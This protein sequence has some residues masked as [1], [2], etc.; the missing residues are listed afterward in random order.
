[1]DL[2]EATD[3]APS[4]RHPWE[5]ARL[6]VLHRLIDRHVP[7]ADGSI[8]VDIGCGDAFVIGELAKAFPSARFYGVDAAFTSASAQQRQRSLP[9]NVHLFSQLD[10]VPADRAAALV[11][12]MDVIE[13]I[14]DDHAFLVD[15][16]RRPIAGATTRAIVTVPAYQSLF[17]SHDIFLKHFRRYTNRQLRDRLEGAGLRIDDI[18]YFFSSLLPLRILSVI[19]E[20]ISPP[21]TASGT[22]LSEYRGGG[23]STALLSGILKAD[24]FSTLM[25]GRL[26]VS[27]PGLSNYAVCRTSA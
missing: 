23:L 3:V 1:M 2:I 16:L 21:D 11:L 19:K 15:L 6:W 20:R 18:G 22:G 8:V 26:G 4:H 24:A 9:P 14:A 7:L 27:L 13:H 12:L 5:L 17:S 25:L 10:D